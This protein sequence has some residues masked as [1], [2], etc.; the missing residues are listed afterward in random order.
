V[1]ICRC[2]EKR[3]A[4][5]QLARKRA[6]QLATLTGLLVGLDPTVTSE[7]V[8]EMLAQVASA[9][10]ARNAL[11]NHVA[12]HPQTLTTG[13]SRMPKAVA[14]F[15]YAAI[16]AGIGGLV[17]PGCALCGRPRTCSTPTSTATASGSAPPATAESVPRPARGA[18]ATDNA[19]D[20]TPPMASPSARDAMTGPSSPMPAPAAVNCVS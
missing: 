14:E 3:R 20:P 12:A 9:A 1:L 4:T 2:G 17:A 11:V 6:A 8:E 19:S 15:I 18:A 16:A 7:R 13:G 5:E 10:G